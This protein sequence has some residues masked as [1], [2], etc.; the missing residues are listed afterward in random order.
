MLVALTSDNKRKISYK[1]SKK[2]GPFFCPCCGA[3]VGLKKGYKKIHH[4]YHF[5]DNPKCINQNE[6]ELHLKVKVEIYERLCTLRNCTDV[7]L[8]KVFPEVRSD[9]FLYIDDTPVTIEIQA[10]SIK[11]EV[12]KKRMQVY[13]SLGINVLWLLPEMDVYEKTGFYS[14]DKEFH[15]LKDWEKVLHEMYGERLYYWISGTTVD[16]VHF[17]KAWLTHD[18][19][20]FWDSYEYEAKKRCEPEYFRKHLDIE[21]DFTYTTS[22]PRLVELSYE[23]IR[24]PEYCIFKDVYEDWW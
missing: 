17:T 15:N 18:G 4:F 22:T 12:I 24:L 20:E 14:S 23:D 7:E 10:S 8:E 19:G 9:I 6:S 1:T 3:E 5:V 13:S 16:A 11:S 21:S 2:E